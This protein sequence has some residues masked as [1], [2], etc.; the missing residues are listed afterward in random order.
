MKKFVSILIL[1]LSAASAG[2]SPP[3]EKV[4][5]DFDWRF[6]L[7]DAPDSGRKFDYPEVSDLAKTRGNEVGKE[8][9][10]AMTMP[11]PPLEDLGEDVSFVRPDFD[12]S[13]WRALD[14]PH[15]WAVEL[16]FTDV[17]NSKELVSHGFKA[18]GPQFS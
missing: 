13:G 11:D 10:L 14:L 2:A 4:S 5:M 9:N 12:D 18:I 7:G 15:D 1:I 17:G 3:R 6:H 8:G 16:P